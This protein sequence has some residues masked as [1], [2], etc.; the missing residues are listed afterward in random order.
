MLGRLAGCGRAD[1]YTASGRPRLAPRRRNAATP[2]PATPAPSDGARGR[3]ST[4]V[5]GSEVVARVGGSDVTAEEL[6]AAI[7]VARA[8]QQAAV[9]RDPALLS[10]TVRAILAN[11]LVLKEALSKKWDQQPAVVAQLARARKT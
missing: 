7:A 3:D 9:A 8:R 11:R 1:T 5:K 10:Q 4:A 2:Q 6:R